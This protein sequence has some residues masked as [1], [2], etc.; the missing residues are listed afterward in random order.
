VQLL[1]GR[2]WVE[3]K[4]AE[5]S[6]FFFTIR[7]KAILSE[8]HRQR[9]QRPVSIQHSLNTSYKSLVDT[10]Q[11][12][13]ARSESSSQL[14]LPVDHFVKASATTEAARPV[15]HFAGLPE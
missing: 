5:G 6:T 4:P 1:N 11:Q 13:A 7:F 3:S 12:K 14:R 9:K 10:G 2:I 15:S 8:K